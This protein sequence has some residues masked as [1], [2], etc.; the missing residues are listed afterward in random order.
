MKKSLGKRRKSYAGNEIL[1]KFKRIRA[2]REFLLKLITAIFLVM[3]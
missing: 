1:N 2:V 3:Q